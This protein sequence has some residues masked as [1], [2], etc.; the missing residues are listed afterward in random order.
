LRET[1]TILRKKKAFLR[2]TKGVLRE[3]GRLLRERVTDIKTRTVK[4]Q[5]P[6]QPTL[7]RPN[8]DP[9]AH[10]GYPFT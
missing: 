1:K 7:A 10:K 8:N 5:K 4:S 9:L 3:T 6:A 2:E